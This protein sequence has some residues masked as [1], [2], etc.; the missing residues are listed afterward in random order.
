M[1]VTFELLVKELLRNA[2]VQS[3]N[4]SSDQIITSI[5]MLPA[6]FCP[7][8]DNMEQN[9]LYLCEYW[10]FKRFDIH[11]ELPPIICVVETCADARSEMFRSHSMAVVYGSTLIEVLLTLANAAYDLGCKSSLITELSRS[12]L[13]CQTIE[14]L[15]EEGYLALKNPL[16]V[17]DNTQK[18]L[19]AIAPDRISNPVY[20]F[21]LASE[22]LP[23]G[24]PL[25]SSLDTAWN[26][27]DVPFLID[28]QEESFPVIC[29]PL[30]VGNIIVGYLHILQFTH[31][32]DQQ[33]INIAEL[34]GNLMAGI[35]WRNR[36]SS[37][38]GQQDGKERFLRDILDN[39]LGE[40]DAALERQRSLGLKFKKHLYAM[41]LNI[42]QFSAQSSAHYILFSDLVSMIRNILPGSCSFLYKS[43]VFA[44]VE[45][46]REIA[47]FDAFLMPLIP[48]LRQ[49][50]LMIG[51]SNEL[52]DIFHL[53]EAG[54]Q[55]RK[56]LQLGASF[57]PDQLIYCYQDFTLHY[58]MELC[59][60]TES[61]ASL[62]PPGLMKL[63]EYS[64]ENGS[65]LLDTLQV[66]LRCG[67]SKS[68]AAKELFVHVNTVKYRI[69]QIQEI[70][71]MDMNDDETALTLMLAFK[72]LEYHDK[73]P[74][75][76]PITN[77]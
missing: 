60:R 36:H 53:R 17:T 35:L 25:L 38:H 39:L 3:Y 49:Y 18:I 6:K 58:M 50:N 21:V 65:E 16:I 23:S 27:V 74:D 37:A 2:S 48:S 30:M 4:I 19:C 43:S 52:P 9:T 31:S 54:Y 34:L 61:T 20:R 76:E 47:D 45:S 71:G 75:Y 5:R 1:Y 70:T 14:E 63:L 12:F 42:K 10:Q 72:M 40:Q 26:A 62:C 41:V 44:L 29:K 11:A 51:I 68:S 13:K 15:L 24:H 73:F 7:G 46:D 66:Y 8:Q 33:D 77:A 56:A 69:A 22:Y 55:C 32:F 28:S 57:H 67:R 64:R 59:L